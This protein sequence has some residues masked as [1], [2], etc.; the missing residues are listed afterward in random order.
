MA[1][2]N[3]PRSSTLLAL[4][5]PYVPSAMSNSFTWSSSARVTSP[6]PSVSASAMAWNLR[7]ASCASARLAGHGALGWCTA[8]GGTRGCAEALAAISTAQA[9]A[10]AAFQLLL[11][12]RA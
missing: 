2:T 1:R 8:R 10:T 5:V 9:P 7:L 4:P 11:T 3:A 12:S 6:S